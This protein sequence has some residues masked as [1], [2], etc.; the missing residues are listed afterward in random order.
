MYTYRTNILQSIAKLCDKRQ[1]KFTKPETVIFIYLLIFVESLTGYS[2][3]NV[4]FSNSLQLSVPD[5]KSDGN[6]DDHDE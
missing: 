6:D 3:E 2:L 1:Q 5:N 4:N